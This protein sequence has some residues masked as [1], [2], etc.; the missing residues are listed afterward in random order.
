MPSPSSAQNRTFLDAV[1]IRN[2]LDH[3]EIKVT[4]LDV[5]T[6]GAHARRS[7]SLYSLAFRDHVTIGV[8][9]LKPDRYD[10]DT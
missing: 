1:V 9:S 8:V 2:W 5:V 7:R 10:L 6:G 3:Q 4:H